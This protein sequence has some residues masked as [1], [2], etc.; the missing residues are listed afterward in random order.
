MFQNTGQTRSVR[1]STRIDFR[2]SFSLAG[3]RVTWRRVCEGSQAVAEEGRGESDV[4]SSAFPLRLWLFGGAPDQD[5][6]QTV[7]SGPERGVLLPQIC[8]LRLQRHLLGE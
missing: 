4:A 6:G 1:V 7:P 8:H 3:N 5:A 2:A